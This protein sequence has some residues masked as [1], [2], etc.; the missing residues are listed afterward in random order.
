MGATGVYDFQANH[1]NL[2]HGIVAVA[3]RV[4]KFSSESMATVPFYAIYGDEDERFLQ[5]KIEERIRE[6]KKLG[7]LAKLKTLHGVLP[8]LLLDGGLARREVGIAGGRV[9]ELGGICV[10][11]QRQA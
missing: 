2:V 3:G 5:S 4:A 9:L 10:C 6:I 11:R 7:G 1:P 8:V